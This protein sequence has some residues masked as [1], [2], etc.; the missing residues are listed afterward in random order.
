MARRLSGPPLISFDEEAARTIGVGIGDTLVVSVLGREIE[1][2]IASLRKINWDSMGF[3]YVMVFSPNALAAAPHS[4]T[5]TIT[6]P[7]AR[8]QPV[9]RALLAAFP[10]VSVIAVSEVIEQISGTAWA[11]VERHRRGSLDRDL[12]R[13]RRAGGRH[14]RLAP[15]AQL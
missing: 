11:D 2:R 8:A 10:G 3:N 14:R 5:A 7:P 9:T 15:G 4:L 6:M 12:R 1:V 13:H